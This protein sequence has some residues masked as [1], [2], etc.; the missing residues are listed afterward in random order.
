MTLRFTATA[1]VGADPQ[2]VLRILG[3]LAQRYGSPHKVQAEQQGD[4]VHIMV[5]V[6]GM[7]GASAQIS[8]CKMEQMVAVVQ[9]EWCD[10]A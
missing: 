5:E 7:G 6:T 9:A 10:A 3:L 8:C 1:K 4:D 2:I